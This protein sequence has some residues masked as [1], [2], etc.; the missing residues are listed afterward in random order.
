MKNLDPSIL[1]A[2]KQIRAKV[3]TVVAD[4][5]QWSILSTG[6]KIAVAMVL[7]RNDLL[8]RAYGSILECVDRLGRDWTTAA[9]HVQREGGWEDDHT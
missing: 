2:I 9:L 1:A 3:R 6:E 4:G 7:N 8:D 5:T